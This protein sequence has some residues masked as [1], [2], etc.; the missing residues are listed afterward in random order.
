MD[1]EQVYGALNR[2][3]KKLQV[4][5]GGVSDYKDLSGK[6]QING[7]TLQGNLTS[8]DLGVMPSDAEIPTATAETI[9]CVMPDGKTIVVDESGVISAKT[10][11]G[12]EFV[13]ENV[14]MITKKDIPFT[15]SNKTY[16]NTRY[17]VSELFEEWDESSEE[18]LGFIAVTSSNQTNAPIV[19]AGTDAGKK[20]SL[21]S[22]SSVNGTYKADITVFVRVHAT[23]GHTYGYEERS[24][25]T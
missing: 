18:F 2:K 15:F 12:S 24:V 8:E 22:P 14:K 10:F 17:K 3:I 25:G 16:S 11:S 4:S 5:G 21:V 1:A 13:T 19:F 20:I 23:V 6:P 7:V 9:G